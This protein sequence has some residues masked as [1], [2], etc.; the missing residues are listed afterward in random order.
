MIALACAAGL[1]GAYAPI[2]GAQDSG[3]QGTRAIEVCLA[4]H[5]VDERSGLG[6][7]LK[8]VLGRSAGAIPAFRYSR[9]LRNAK[10]V[11]DEKTLDAYLANPQ[12]VV[13]GNAMP[14]AGIPDS[15]ERAAVIEY[16]K[17]LK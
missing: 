5:T 14:F 13:P 2:A 6:P 8:G 12:K 1:V 3:H 15:K 7:S 16:L 9:A 4:C 10:F 11:W 17:T